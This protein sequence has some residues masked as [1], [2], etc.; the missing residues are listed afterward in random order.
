MHNWGQ[1][2]GIDAL[3]DILF[4]ENEENKRKSQMRE[5]II[6]LFKSRCVIMT[7]WV[8]GGQ[9]ANQKYYFDI[10]F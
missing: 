1:T 10:L 7:E 2:S 5:T 8:T 9:T 6:V 3:E 4:T